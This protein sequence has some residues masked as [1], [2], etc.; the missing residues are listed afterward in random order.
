[1]VSAIKKFKWARF[2]GD[3]Q[4]IRCYAHVLN[5]IAQSILRPFG[6][7][8]KRSTS[9]ASAEDAESLSDNSEGE[10]AEGQIRRFD[11]DAT[12]DTD[13]DDNND[14]RDD[15]ESLHPHD[16]EPELNLED[17]CGLSDED[18]DNDLYTT[19]MCRQS[20]A[21]FRAVARKLRKSPNSKIEFVE[22]FS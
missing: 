9:E 17:I 18:E 1:M 7:V 14:S 22:L 3:Q 12:Y 15:N 10:D 16:L 6:S 20:L 2:K 4:W 19:S 5:L 8:N 13:S 21:K 11:H